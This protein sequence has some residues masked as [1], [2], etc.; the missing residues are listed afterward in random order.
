[1][2]CSFSPV[3]RSGSDC[4]SR[5]TSSWTR[6]SAHIPA[7]RKVPAGF[8]PFFA[9]THEPVTPLKEFAI[10]SAGFW[11]QHASN[12]FILI[13]RPNLRDEHAPFVKGLVA[14]NVLTS[15]MYAVAA[16]ARAGP[17]ERD[18]RG[19]AVSAQ[20]DGAMDRGDGPGAGSAR[21]RALLPA[22]VAR[23]EV[24]EPRREN[25]RRAAVVLKAAN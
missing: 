1:M 3:L 9:I 23:A 12:E 11:V 20:I 21:R 7:V 5:V 13:R 22:E 19:M 14:F 18:T 2:S 24:G 10:S 16:F 6:R 15:V 17:A 25:R 4:T 8:I